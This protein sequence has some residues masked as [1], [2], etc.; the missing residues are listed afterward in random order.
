MRKFYLSSQ[1]VNPSRLAFNHYLFAK[2]AATLLFSTRQS[3]PRLTH[4]TS[5]RW[6]LCPAVELG[7]GLWWDMNVL[8]FDL[9]C[10]VSPAASGRDTATSPFAAP[11]PSNSSCPSGKECLFL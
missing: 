1:S 6:A 8:V 2:T 3:W 11:R 7:S 10:L 9:V 4:L 5:L